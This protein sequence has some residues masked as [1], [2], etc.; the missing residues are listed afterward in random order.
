MARVEIKEKS[1]VVHMDGIHKFM[2]FKNQLE[3]PLAQIVDAW[4]GIDAQTE[5]EFKH[6][7]R[8]PGSY[9]PGLI[10][11]GSYVGK[12]DS[13]FWDV[14]KKSNAIVIKLEHMDPHK[15]VIEVEDQAGTVAS[16]KEAIAQ[17]K[18]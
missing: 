8:L 1:L 3:I 7:W 12:D 17:A 14:H 13:Q 2:A 18:S 16:I 15:I 4:V 11:A 9:M 10:I 6:L 5:E